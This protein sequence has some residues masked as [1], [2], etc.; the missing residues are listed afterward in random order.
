MKNPNKKRHPFRTVLIVLLGIV[1]FCAVAAVIG[2]SRSGAG[3]IREYKY[4]E[5]SRL[6]EDTADQGVGRVEVF[7]LKLDRSMA[8]QRASYSFSGRVLVVTRD[9]TQTV[10]SSVNDD[11][12][13]LT[14]IYRGTS[15][16][17]SRLLPFWDNT[18]I[19]MGDSIL[20]CPD[21]YTLDNCPTDAGKMVP[22]I[23]PD[24]FSKG[25]HVV[26]KWTEVIISPDNEHIAWTIRRSDCGATNAMGRLVRTEN[27][28]EIRDAQYISNMNAFRP[29]PEHPGLNLYTPEIGGEVK[30]FVQG[31][32]AISLVGAA[33][34]GMADSIVQDI[35][36]GE[37]TLITRNPGYDETTIFSPD[38]KLGIVMTTRFSETTDMAVLG[39]VPRPFGEVLHNILGQVYMYGVT[40]VCSSREGNIGPALINIEKSMTEEGYM[41]L[42]LSDP[43]RVWMY[44]SPMS[45]KSDGTAA[46]W[47]ERE[48]GGS[49]V[50]VQI[51]KLLDYQPGEPV[52]ATDTP[53]VGG[54]A[55]EP[56]NL[57]NYDVKVQGTVSGFVTIK[58]ETV[59]LNKTTVTAVYEN[60][61]DDGQVFLN[62][63]ETSSGAITAK[64]TYKS[65]LTLTGA[66]GSRLGCMDVDLT[67][68]AAY[69]IATLFTGRTSP[70][71]DLNAS[72]GT[73]DWNGKHA[74]LEQ[75]VP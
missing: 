46:M 40:G 34:C 6:I 3:R 19:L 49:G 70:S 26:D 4:V 67:M 36:T 2:L 8:V 28:Y 54:Y 32:R 47:I 37:V 31:G 61:S 17:G 7:T 11:G 39:L 27:S 63:T 60:Y 41:G 25:P 52:A 18:R 16:G 21:G 33:P 23:F 74:G 5:G 30:Q 1:V 10:I 57:G 14:E 68:S 62:G 50:R 58:K 75:L 24:A 72:Y 53:A 12:T 56:A 65:N 43:D 22:I 20:E 48:K 29:D 15:R 69:S 35:A 13:D 59:F 42:D 71:L 55:Q 44:N 64:T 66:D 9:G 38:E 51:V 45:W 73:A